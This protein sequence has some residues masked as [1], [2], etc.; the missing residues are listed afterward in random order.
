MASLIHLNAASLK[1]LCKRKIPFHINV[2]IVVWKLFYCL[3]WLKETIETLW[4]KW[5]LTWNNG[6]LVMKNV[7]LKHSSTLKVRIAQ[8]LWLCKCCSAPFNA[9]YVISAI[10]GLWIITKTR[11]WFHQEQSS[12]EKLLETLP[13]FLWWHLRSIPCSL[14]HAHFE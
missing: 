8:C 10:R 5:M 12:W 6:P 3:V 1:W 4:Q 2:S 9:Q 14:S 7:F 11:T 13:H